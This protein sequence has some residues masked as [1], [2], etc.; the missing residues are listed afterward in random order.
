MKW[1]QFR[2]KGLQRLSVMAAATGLALLSGTAT[3]AGISEN[4]ICNG[5][6]TFAELQSRATVAGR[7]IGIERARG[8]G[9]DVFDLIVTSDS[10]KVSATFQITQRWHNSVPDK[11]LGTYVVPITTNDSQAEDLDNRLFAKALAPIDVPSNVAANASSAVWEDVN[12][13]VRA[14]FPFQV[15]IIPTGWKV[16]DPRTGSYVFIKPNDQIT[17]KFADGSSAKMSFTGDGAM[18]IAW[19]LVPGSQRQSNG[20]P[21]GQVPRVYTR[22][23]IIFWYNGIEYRWRPAH[24]NC[25]TE[26]TSCSGLSCTVRY[27]DC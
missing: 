9:D 22:P 24:N 3:A 6:T 15:S 17:V 27:N 4:A 11:P 5:C 20:A 19:I 12:T 16:L 26:T 10:S 13:Y 25:G 1:T 8:F 2:I 21:Y 18:T 14:T 23:L 7:T